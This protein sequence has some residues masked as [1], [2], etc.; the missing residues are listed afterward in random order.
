MRVMSAGDG[1]KYLLKTVAAGDGD[2]D[3]S[4]PLTRYYAEAGTPP[5]YWLGEGVRSLGQGALGPGDLVSEAQLQLLVGLGR[6]PM[7]GEPLGRAY[8]VYKSREQR[9]ADR[10]GELDSGPR[11]AGEPILQ[12]RR[13]SERKYYGLVCL[14]DWSAISGGLPQLGRLG[15]P[16]H[17]QQPRRHDW[18]HL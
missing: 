5:G 2:R 8:P 11:M 16:T 4:T 3:L 12:H 1:Y 13:L 10:V 6:D 14:G 15:L 17:C 9:I 7:T 18:R